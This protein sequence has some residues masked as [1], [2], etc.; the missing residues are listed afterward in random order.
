MQPRCTAR[1]RNG[2]QCK[3]PSI[4]GATTCRMHG[5][6]TK[7]ARAAAARR[8][9][10]ADAE[11]TLAYVGSEKYDDPLMELGKLAS[12]ALAMKSAL[13]ARVNALSSA[14]YTTFEGREHL[15]VE[16][17]LYERA[18]DRCAK[19]LEVLSRS[20]FEQRRI[21]LEEE[22]AK[23]LVTFANLIADRL[24]ITDRAAYIETVQGVLT[25]MAQQYETGKER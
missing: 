11:A 21:R 20:G 23:Q 8:Q 6:A 4:T 19:F 16:V 7:R 24:G 1:T 10:R 15:R 14:T 9:A 17:E 12:E 13:A 25:D 22:T 5:S 3:N 18:L 2:D